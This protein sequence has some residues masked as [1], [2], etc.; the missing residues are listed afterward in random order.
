MAGG[1][2]CGSHVEGGRQPVRGKSQGLCWE[3]PAAVAWAAEG[4]MFGGVS[5]DKVPACSGMSSGRSVVTKGT[6]LKS[7]LLGP[8]LIPPAL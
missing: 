7:D 8:S 5:V 2:G 4:A 6:A 1:L 3:S